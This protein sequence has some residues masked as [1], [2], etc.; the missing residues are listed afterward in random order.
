MKKEIEV[1]IL[2][3][4]QKKLK[5][6]LKELGARRVFG[7]TLFH[8]I[9][10]ESPS[11]E[12]RYSSFRLRSEGKKNFLTLKLKKDDLAFEIRD[13][14]EMEIKDFEIALKILQLAGF[15]VFRQREKL[16]EEYVLENVKI[17]IDEYPMMMPYMEIEAPSKKIM[18]NFLKKFNFSFKYTTN[19]TATEIIQNA[20]LNPD[21][22]LFN[23]KPLAN[24]IFNKSL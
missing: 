19:R 20:G 6:S 23:K 24:K 4:D 12:R 17:E 9:Y 1:K 2:N 7:R 11:K 15:K 10:L 8:E 5:K 22:L 3:I 16:R 21:N 13:E 18:K 14:F